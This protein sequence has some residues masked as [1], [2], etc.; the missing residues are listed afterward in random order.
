MSRSNLDKAFHALDQ[1]KETLLERSRYGAVEDN[2]GHISQMGS[3]LTGQPMTKA[4]VC[5]FMIA[6]KLSRLS[7]KDK[8]NINCNHV[9]SYIDIIGYAA[10][11]LELLDNGKEEG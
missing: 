11:A 9:D 7:A 10:I 4:Q 5:A 6:V 8:D 1:T 2:F 3:M